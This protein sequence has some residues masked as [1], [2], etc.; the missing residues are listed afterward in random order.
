MC[1]ILHAQAIFKKIF[2][3]VVIA[4]R[5]DVCVCLV[6]AR[7]IECILASIKLI[8]FLVHSIFKWNH[9][10]LFSALLVGFLLS[11]T[12]FITLYERESRQRSDELRWI[13]TTYIFRI[14]K[15]KNLSTRPLKIFHIKT[16]HTLIAH[17]N[18]TTRCSTQ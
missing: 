4:K 1:N 9:L 8:K 15:K 14:L 3:L 7:D 11:Q 12:L 2:P 6:M 10:T 18:K 17:V 16:Q 5:M 13:K